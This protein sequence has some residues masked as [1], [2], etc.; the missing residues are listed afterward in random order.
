MKFR[1]KVLDPAPVDRPAEWGWIGELAAEALSQAAEISLELLL[2][3]EDWV[4]RRVETIELI[5]QSR[6]RQSVSVDFRLP[7]RLPGSFE[8]A[9]KDHYVLPLLVLPRRSDL[10]C[11]D[12]RDESGRALPILTRSENARL[13]GLMLLGA[14][15]RA[16]AE[17]GAGG[18]LPM[19]LRTFLAA[20]P[21]YPRSVTRA[22]VAEIVA[23]QSKLL[24]ISP[25]FRRLLTD[26]DF[27]NLLGLFQWASAIHVPLQVDRGERRIVKISWEGRWGAWQLPEGSSGI[28]TSLRRAWSGSRGAIGWRPESRVLDLPQLGGANSHHLQIAAPSGVE[29]SEVRAPNGPPRLMLPGSSGLPDPRKDP[30][31]PH[32][33]AA[34]QRVHLY[35]PRA[36]EMRVGVLEVEL[37]TSRHGLLTAALLTGIFVTLMLGVYAA[38]AEEIVGQS[39]TGAAI[40]LLVP[41]LLAGFLVRP[42][43]HEMARVLLRAPRFM[44]TALGILPLVAAGALVAAP[45]PE[46]RSGLAALLQVPASPLPGWLP[47]LW[48]T[49]ATAA[50][51]L[52]LALAGC[53]LGRGA[54]S[55]DE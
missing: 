39:D 54:S 35:L 55:A 23:P 49:L 45:N 12:V 25:G 1:K 3:G 43:E 31:Q 2:R 24:P 46:E 29:L 28:G 21:K 18:E 13:S 10:A 48:W 19:P 37:R 42:G 41:A 22:I 6:V 38:R 26:Q 34:S 8:I 15:E 32:S 7:E 4:N 9:G 17:A 33:E 52:T 16:I 51:I 44:T 11:F 5:D 14:A 47:T 27:R 36:H 30:H 20:L 50:A 53:Y 40:L